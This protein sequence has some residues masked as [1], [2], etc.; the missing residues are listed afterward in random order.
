MN[1]FLVFVR[2]KSWYI[3]VSL[4]RCSLFSFQGMAKDL[5]APLYHCFYIK[6]CEENYYRERKFAYSD[7]I[8]SIQTIEALNRI[9]HRL[10]PHL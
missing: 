3:V 2:H 6:F 4:G 1:I 5:S 9:T 10:L 7:V 8:D